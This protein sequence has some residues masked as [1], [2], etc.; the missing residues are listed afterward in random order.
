MP[1]CGDARR[2]HVGLGVAY[3]VCAVVSDA[4]SGASRTSWI[5]SMHGFPGVPLLPSLAQVQ[6]GGTQPRSHHSTVPI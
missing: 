2:R 1:A 5:I 4:S 3:R 6:I